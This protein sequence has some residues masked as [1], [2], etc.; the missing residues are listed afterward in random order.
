MAA[1]HDREIVD[2]AAFGPSTCLM[3]WWKISIG[4]LS[5]G[6]PLAILAIGMLDIKPTVVERGEVLRLQ[7]TSENMCCWFLVE[8]TGPAKLVCH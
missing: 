5:I 3:I 8:K 1:C 7:A 2:S 6:E 4:S